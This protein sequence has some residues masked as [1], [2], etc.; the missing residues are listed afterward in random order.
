MFHWPNFSVY[1]ECEVDYMTAIPQNLNQKDRTYIYLILSIVLEY[2]LA[3]NRCLLV[4]SLSEF[5]CF[6]K[7]LDVGE[8]G[9]GK[10]VRNHY[11]VYS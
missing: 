4:M 5:F 6:W 2:I 10:H 3:Y 1:L 8:G 11:R 7:K 9:L